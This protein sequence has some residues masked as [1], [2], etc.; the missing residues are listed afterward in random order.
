MLW[1]T[2]WQKGFIEIQ[3]TPSCSN[4]MHSNKMKE[5]RHLSIEGIKRI[6]KN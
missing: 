1:E 6:L 3:K 5:K 2:T 4:E